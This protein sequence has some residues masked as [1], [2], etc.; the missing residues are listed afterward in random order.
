MLKSYSYA[1][2]TLTISE[3]PPRHPVHKIQTFF[4]Y[5]LT[6]ISIKLFRK[7]YKLTQ[8]VCSRDVVTLK[9]ILVLY[10]LLNIKMLHN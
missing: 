1:L 4:L 5:P 2:N 9:M 7:K 10:N 8:N 6:S 3:C